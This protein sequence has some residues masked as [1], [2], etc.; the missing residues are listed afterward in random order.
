MEGYLKSIDTKWKHI[1]KRAVR[2][3]GKIPLEELYEVYGIKHNLEPGEEFIK[4]LKEVK[5]KNQN[6]SWEIVLSDDS[7]PE[8]LKEEV[9]EDA[10]VTSGDFQRKGFT[11]EDIVNLSVRKAREILPHITDLRLLQ[12]SL[13]EARP[14]ANK[15]SLC[16]MLEK[17]INELQASI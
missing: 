6:D 15:D 13:K 3:G 1:F 4:W 11:V 17:R 8:D 2:P 10:G 9:I 14:R 12:Y 7:T 16:R 5:L